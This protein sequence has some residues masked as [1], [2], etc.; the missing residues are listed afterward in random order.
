MSAL[1]A[2]LQLLRR[3]DAPRAVAL[4][5]RL[6]AADPGDL[7]VRHLLGVALL[8]AGRPGDAE[9]ELAGVLAVD[10]SAAPVHFNHGNALAELGRTAEAA[11]AY[12]AAL[13]RQPGMIEA[14][15]NLGNALMRLG[16][17]EP[18]IAAFRR[19]LAAR[20]NLAEARNGLGGALLANGQAAEALAALDAAIAVDPSLAEAHDNRGL[21]LRELGRAEEAV[22]SHARA[23]SL[24]PDSVSARVGRALALCAAGRP[25][26][27]L[28]DAEAALRMQRST[29][30]LNCRGLVYNELGRD[31]DARTDFVEVL[32]S[33]PDAVETRNNLGNVLH[34]LGRCEEA[35]EQFRIAAAAKPDFAQAWSNAGMVLQD[36]RRFDEAEAAYAS[37]IALRPDAAEAY[38]RR[39][40]L[41]LLQG[42][43]RRGWA[44]FDAS[45]SR[46]R[47]LSPGSF[48]HIPHWRGESLAGRTLL[49]SEPSGIGDTLQ[50]WRF[51]P[52]LL[53]RGARVS[54]C[55]PPRLSALL[56]SSG[57]PVRFVDPPPAGERF[58][59][60]AELW[61]LPHLLGL[62]LEDVRV[63]GPYLRPAEARRK[64]VAALLEPDRINIG[65]CWQGNPE[66]KIDAGRSIPLAEFLAL[67]EDPRV[68]L[69]S[70][71]RMHG[72]DQLE[73]LPARHR[74]VDPGPDFDAGPDAFADT[75]A[76][77]AGLDLVVS[78]DTA[79]AH[80]AGALGVPA[81]IGLK[82]TPEWRW[83][84]DRD[85]SPWYPAARLFRQ[86]SAGDWAGVFAAMAV[87]LEARFP[88]A[89]R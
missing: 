41:R 30:T 61:T 70:L 14:A 85:D 8:V 22:A 23:L 79:I 13:S 44:D 58:D 56:G 77:M 10:A 63:D 89:S 80:L 18:A 76:L 3:G 31:E 35:L 72:L 54:F 32:R 39:A 81:W 62:G 55:G 1:E 53:E 34:D 26:P 49:V 69:V 7:A 25:L 73:A 78:S 17:L 40:T 83:M 11:L 6:L 15:C 19:A 12:E 51:V 86:P 57:W 36:L 21:A 5:R 67:A 59:F 42:D 9:R 43:F 29:R 71:Q 45:L 88:R 24:A 38:K 64:R 87:A 60:Q 68:R 50:F 20:P 2:A 46:A 82:W 74:I 28:G 65:I 37:A 75:A 27:A 52:R 48:A 66:R 4:C 84:L 33:D 47:R 16:R